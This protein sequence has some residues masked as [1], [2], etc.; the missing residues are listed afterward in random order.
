VRNFAIL[1]RIL[2]RENDAERVSGFLAVS[3]FLKKSQFIS[4][5][6]KGLSLSGFLALGWPLIDQNAARANLK[7]GVSDRWQV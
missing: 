7:Q 1:G 4:Q 6:V 5:W 3:G 2:A